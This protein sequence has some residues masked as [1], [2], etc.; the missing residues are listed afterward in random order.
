MAFVGSTQKQ[1]TRKKQKSSLFGII[2]N[3]MLIAALIFGGYVCIQAIAVGNNPIAIEDIQESANTVIYDRNGE[4]FEVIGNG[5]AKDTAVDFPEVL[6]NA[7]LAVEDKRFYEHSGVDIIRTSKVI[8]DTLVKR[9]FGAGGSTITQQLVKNVTGDDEVSISR[10]VREM[11]YAMQLEQQCS[12]EQILTKYLNVIY[13]GKGNFGMVDS[14]KAYFG[15]SPEELTIAE[16]AFMAAIIKSPETYVNDMDRANDRKNLVLSYMLEQEKISE[17]EYEEA[18]NKFVEVD[19]KTSSG[20]IYSWFSESV[21]YE[22]ATMYAETHKI[23][24]NEA[25]DRVMSGGYKIYSTVDPDLQSEVYSLGRNMA[26]DIGDVQSATLVMNKAGEVVACSGAAGKKR[27][28]LDFNRAVQTRRQPGSAI[29]PLAVYGPA[30][31]ENRISTMSVYTDKE[32]SYGE[33]TPRNFYRDYYGDMTVRSALAMSNNSIPV[34]ILYEMGTETGIKYLEDMGFQTEAEDN[35]LTL[36]VGAVSKGYTL[37]EMASGYQAILNGGTWCEPIFFTKIVA[38]SGTII[39]N[40]KMQDTKKV[41]SEDTAY[42]LTDMLRSVVESEEGTAKNVAI[43]GMQIAAKTGTTSNNRDKWCCAFNPEYVVVTWCG[44]DKGPGEIDVAS[45]YIQKHIRK[46]LKATPTH[47][48]TFNV[49][50][51]VQFV[52]I[53]SAT[54]MV[55]N[56]NCES[57]YTEVIKTSMTIDTCTCEGTIIDV[58]EDWWNDIQDTNEVEEEL[59]NFFNGIGNIFGNYEVPEETTIVEEATEE[60]IVEDE[61]NYY[62]EEEITIDNIAI[63]EEY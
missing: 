53:C 3:M 45:S 41:F 55:S 5:N 23:S 30:I 63:P 37:P 62:Y 7:V 12:K 56:G 35:A 32:I 21:L 54:G 59:N 38:K 43:D 2:V 44:Y 25:L 34:Q 6:E 8:I 1:K 50:E 49:P 40:E 52:D 36:A 42:I 18:C 27:A 4:I 48:N 60:V 47:Q 22:F 24:Y 29:K 58:V 10:K 9:S 15:K 28:N 61:S 31:E 19:A 17:A 14:C 20:N 26:S 51:T 57:T 39:Y 46:V 13:L 11:F 33:W 16:A